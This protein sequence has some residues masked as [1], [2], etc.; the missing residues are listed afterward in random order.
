MIV[1]VIVA[2]RICFR[3]R[4]ENTDCTVMPKGS[5]DFCCG[6]PACRTF[7]PTNVVGDLLGIL[8]PPFGFRGTHFVLGSQKPVNSGRTFKEEKNTRPKDAAINSPA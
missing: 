6:V 2:R 4:L 7:D 5:T 8:W 3:A 1:I